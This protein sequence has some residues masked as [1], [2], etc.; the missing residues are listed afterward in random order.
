MN[1]GEKRGITPDS[2]LILFTIRTRLGIVAHKKTGAL[3]PVLCDPQALQLPGNETLIKESYL[4]PDSFVNK[5][6]VFINLSEQG[7]ETMPLNSQPNHELKS[8][9]W[10]KGTP[11]PGS[12][13]KVWMQDAAGNAIR[14]SDYG[15]R[16]SA[17]GWEIDHIVATK[18]GG[19]DHIS[20]L[21]PLHWKLNATLGGL[22]GQ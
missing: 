14:W 3:T 6:V 1:D 9:V 19:S 5:A 8:S 13:S 20:N 10:W 7:E 16:N 21:R 17:Y 15:D 18:S 12:D 11:I 4:V 2:I 22:L